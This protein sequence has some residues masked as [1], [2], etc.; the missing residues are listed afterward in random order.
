M[1]IE[2]ANQF[3]AE[4]S[5]NAIPLGF[6]IRNLSLTS[7]MAI[8]DNDTGVEVLLDLEAPKKGKPSYAFRISSVAV[9]SDAWTEHCSGI[10][11][12][13]TVKHGR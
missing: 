2:A 6:T 10:V 11:V 1:A 5:R 12:P 13:L 3:F 9:G 4:S 8:P 7:A